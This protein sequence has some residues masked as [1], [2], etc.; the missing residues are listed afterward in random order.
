VTRLRIVVVVPGFPVEQDGPGLAAVVDLV[1]RIGRVHICR[2]VALASAARP[3]IRS[4]A[5]A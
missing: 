3:P 2:V 1:E 5:F 4:P